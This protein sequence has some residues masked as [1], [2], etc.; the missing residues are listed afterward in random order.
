MDRFSGIAEFVAA[1]ETGSFRGAGQRLGLT[2]SGISKAVARL[3]QRLGSV[4]LNRT[5]RSLHLT[6]MGAEFFPEAR[7]LL[8]QLEELEAG[9]TQA[10]DELRG[11]LRVEAPPAFGRLVVMPALPRFLLAY[12]G[13]ELQLFLRDRLVDLAEEG[14]DAAIRTGALQPSTLVARRLGAT[15]FVTCAAPAYLTRAGVPRTPEE[16]LQHNCLGYVPS[17][18]TRPRSWRF[19]RDG[20]PWSTQPTGSLA[21]DSTEGLAEAALQGVGIIQVLDFVVTGP[22]RQGLLLPVL[23]EWAGPERPISLVYAASSRR[24][25]KVQAFSEFAAGLLPMK[26]GTS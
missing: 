2:T 26:A 12:P 9:L 22:I 19:A 7:R 18:A 5:T 25:A 6:G 23:E 10:K 24:T 13:I 1:V 17:H 21:L 8:R 16:L 3:E 14:I 11:R 15:R 4:L 20:A